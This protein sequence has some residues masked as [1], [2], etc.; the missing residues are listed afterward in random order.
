MAAVCAWRQSSPPTRGIICSNGTKDHPAILRAD[1]AWWLTAA[2][3]DRRA[4]SRLRGPAATGRMAGCDGTRRWRRGACVGA[5]FLPWVYPE[6]YLFGTAF[7]GLAAAT[8]VSLS[9]PAP[10][11]WRVRLAGDLRDRHA[12]GLQHHP[13]Q[14]ALVHHFAAVAVF[15]HRRGDARRTGRRAAG[16]R[17]ETA[18]CLGAAAAVWSA[19]F[20]RGPELPPPHRRQPG[21]ERELRLRAELQRCLDGDELPARRGAGRPDVSCNEDGVILC[22]S[23]YPLAVAAGGFRAHRL[24]QRHNNSPASPDG[25]RVDFLLVTDRRVE[26]VESKLDDDVLQ[27]AHPPASGAGGTAALPA[28]LAFSPRLMPADREP[29][30]HP[31]PKPRPSR[32]P[33]RSWA[34]LL[35]MTPPEPAVRRQRRRGMKRNDR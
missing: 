14:D 17:P 30:F 6:P 32:R 22:D 2:G 10:G 5:L 27:T 3:M 35:P 19:D 20:A 15:L 34:R 24:L 18:M 11:D 26:E 4:G 9:L 33:T 13:L 21:K 31:V 7:V 16:D 8:V 25:Y 28:R 29:E 12:A 1:A 23:T